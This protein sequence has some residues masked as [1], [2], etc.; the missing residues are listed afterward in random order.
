[1][2]GA[3]THL[4]ASLVARASQRIFVSIPA[5]E[6]LLKPHVTSRT[7]ISW[8]PLPSGIPVVDDSSKRESIRTLYL[9]SPNGQIL[10]HFGTCGRG[11]TEMLMALLPFLLVANPLRAA[12][13]LGRG[14][15][16]L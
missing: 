13:L 7:K 9:P 8:L 6:D 12:L 16:E 2:L 14:G 15:E 3:V 11:I 5:W 10:G 1:M 4:M